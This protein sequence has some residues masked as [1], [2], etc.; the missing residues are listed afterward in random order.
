MGYGKLG[1][2]LAKSILEAPASAGLEI[3]FVW[4]RTASK[5][6]EDD[7]ISENLVLEDLGAF[8]ERK[9]DL[10][11]EVAHPAITEEYGAK[12]LEHADFF[13]GS[14][15]C[16]ADRELEERIRAAAGKPNGHGLYV[17]AGALW[18]AMDIQK[19]AW[20]S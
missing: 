7:R 20:V 19:M 13:C 17:P 10:I 8:A 3:A 5:I 2:Y 16:F 6:R 18:G 9:A 11:V 14:P 1:Q 15:T 4:N 12:F